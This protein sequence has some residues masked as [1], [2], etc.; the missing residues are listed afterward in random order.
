M[1]DITRKRVLQ[2]CKICHKKTYYV[3]RH[4]LCIDCLDEKVK[5]ARSQIRMKEGPIYEKWK[6]KLINSLSRLT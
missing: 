6:S 4:G 5:L 3:S 2:T 1:K